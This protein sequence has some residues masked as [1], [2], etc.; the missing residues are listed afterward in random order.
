MILQLLQGQEEGYGGQKPFPSISQSSFESGMKWMA[1]MNVFRD[2][3]KGRKPSF[4]PF[5]PTAV[6]RAW[7]VFGYE[8]EYLLVLMDLLCGTTP[9]T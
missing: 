2:L 1:E 9:D 8:N 7:T 6:P 3:P 4:V 5:H